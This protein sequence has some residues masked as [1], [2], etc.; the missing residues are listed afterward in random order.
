MCIWWMMEDIYIV[1]QCVAIQWLSCYP[2]KTRVHADEAALVACCVLQ[3]E[4]SWDFMLGNKLATQ[5]K[6]GIETHYFARMLSGS[7]INLYIIVRPN[8]IMCLFPIPTWHPP[9][10]PK[11]L[12]IWP[13]EH[14]SLMGTVLYLWVWWDNLI[15]TQWKRP[16][17]MWCQPIRSWNFFIRSMDMQMWK[18]IYTILQDLYLRRKSKYK[19]LIFIFRL[20][21]F[22]LTLIL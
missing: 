17:T 14:S 19:H 22:V 15:R 10:P 7:V 11:A 16:N 12:Y 9:P 5:Q 8:K 18:N 20:V 6:W 21:L 13:I 3:A 4:K 2:A 1:C